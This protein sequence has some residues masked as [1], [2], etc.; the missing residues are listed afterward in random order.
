MSVN[1]KSVLGRGRPHAADPDNPGRTVP[2]VALDRSGTVPPL[3]LDMIEDQEHP[4][5]STA[6]IEATIASLGGELERARSSLQ[7]AIDR[8][9]DTAEKVGLR[10]VRTHIDALIR[11]RSRAIAEAKRAMLRRQLAAIEKEL[12]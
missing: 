10:R 6:L 11:W 9:T 2:R 5:D 7:T 12:E 1:P 3:P 8:S 4:L